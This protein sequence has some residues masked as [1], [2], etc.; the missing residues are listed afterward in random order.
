M[1][2]SGVVLVAYF[3]TGFRHLF[4]L[5]DE[6]MAA[7][8]CTFRPSSRSGYAH[9]YTWNY[10]GLWWLHPRDGT[11]QHRPDG[12]QPPGWYRSSENP[13]EYRLWSG[14][15]WTEKTRPGP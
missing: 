10:D 9:R 11:V 3:I 6:E 1:L 2:G 5:L 7:G 12:S 14:S 13:N 4:Q 8:Y 15:A